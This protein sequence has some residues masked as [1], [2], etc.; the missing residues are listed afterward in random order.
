MTDEVQPKWP[1]I[2]KRIKTR[3]HWELIARPTAFPDRPLDRRTLLDLVERCQVRLRGWYFPH[4]DRHEPAV[5]TKD[6]VGQAYQFEHSIEHWRMYTS[7]QFV[8]VCGVP[9]EWRDGSS[10]WPA[11]DS[12]KPNEVLGVT[13]V[14]FRMIE[15]V[16]F[17]SRLATSEAGGDPTY[18][19]A[20]L[21][22][23]EGRRLVVD[24]PNRAPLMGRYRASAQRIELERSVQREE[25]VANTR[26]IA[27]S[28]TEELFGYF[29]WQ[30]APGIVQGVQ[31]ELLKR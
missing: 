22:P 23:V 4:V 21:S 1:E 14:T 12:W 18:L 20:A 16:S 5:V 24:N 17:A 11:G 31:D 2:L 25:L 9:H 19:R 3:G 8:S 30:P 28:L 29:G 10:F 7:G 26:E 13:E 15:F 6:W 27:A